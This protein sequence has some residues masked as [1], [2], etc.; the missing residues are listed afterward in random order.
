MITVTQANTPTQ[1]NAV[2]GLM[3]SFIA[4]HRERHVE[5]LEL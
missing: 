1:L 3:R 2:R 5:D 4:W